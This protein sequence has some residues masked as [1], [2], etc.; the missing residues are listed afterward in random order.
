MTSQQRIVIKVGSSTLTG[1]G[2]GID[3][4]FVSTLV[5]QIADVVGAG[6]QVVLVS[7]G[8][9]AAGLD[10]LD[11][12]ERPTDMPSLQAAASVGQVVLAETY[13]TLFASHGITVGQVLLT[14][15]DTGHR[16]SFLH[17]RDTFERLLSLG[18]VP[19]VNENDTVAVDE[20]RFGD[21]D[22]LAALVA[23]MVSANLVLLL[24]D[25]A[26]LYDADPR[27]SA[28]AKLLEHVEELTDDLV[29]A[30]GGSG[31]DVGSGGMATKLDAANM[32]MKAGIPMVICDGRRADVIADAVAGRPVGTLFAGGDATLSAR[33]LWIALGRNPA[34]EI[35]IDDGARD[36]LVKRNTSLLPAGV[37]GVS[38]PFAAGDAVVL[39]DRSGTIV[40]RG[41]T[42]LSSA[43]LET[44][45]GLKSSQIAEVCPAVAG[46]EVVHRDHLV[47]L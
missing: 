29:A 8:A 37:V 32:L 34:G 10:R 12:A 22:S 38:G 13:Q 5:E 44:V 30:A 47:V 21:N 16:E 3:R 39:R 43:D 20:I 25:I 42:E 36:A 26:G 24:S 4:E 17:A 1:E 28:E 14:R 2:G 45:K 15:H 19:V 6:A 40:A 7:S 18:A 11:L 31:S 27:V 9:I 23:T 35:V 33:K 46:K 41:L